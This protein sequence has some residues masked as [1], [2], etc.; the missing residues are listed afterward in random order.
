[1]RQARDGNLIRQTGKGYGQT[2]MHLEKRRA[3]VAFS[4]IQPC[5]ILLEDVMPQPHLHNAPVGFTATGA[6]RSRR[7]SC[8]DNKH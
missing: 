4:P 1:M 5:S 7:T 6:P 3:G 2:K 8:L